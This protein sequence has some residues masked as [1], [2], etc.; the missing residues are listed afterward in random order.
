MKTHYVKRTALAVVGSVCLG[1]ICTA[2]IS[3]GAEKKS[4]AP[5]QNSGD[6]ATLRV[7]RTPSV[8][9]GITVNL[10]IDGKLIMTVGQGR[11]YRGP[12]TPGKH[13]ISVAPDP[14]LTGQQPNKVEVNAEKGQS[15]S[16]NVGAKS[17]KIELTKK[18]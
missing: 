9:S 1:V 8:G 6:M 18:P 13:V 12:L 16:F 10:S 4:E 17:G 11:S 15:Y 5:A 3:R 2:G 7:A 14:N